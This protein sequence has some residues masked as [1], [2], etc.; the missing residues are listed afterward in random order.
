MAGTERRTIGIRRVKTATLALVCMRHLAIKNFKPTAFF[1]VGLDLT[2]GTNTARLWHKRA[3]TNLL[4]D[5][6]EAD[7]IAAGAASYSGPISV[8]K[9]RAAELPPKLI[10]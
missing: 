3:H 4:T 5:K 7:A 2:D 9:K 6:R 8:A 10:A 1:E